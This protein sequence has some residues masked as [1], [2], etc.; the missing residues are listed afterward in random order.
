MRQECATRATHRGK[1]WPDNTRLSMNEKCHNAISMNQPLF[2]SDV[3]KMWEALMERRRTR[4]GMLIEDRHGKEMER[5]CVRTINEDCLISKTLWVYMRTGNGTYI[6]ALRSYVSVFCDCGREKERNMGGRLREDTPYDNEQNNKV[7][8]PE[9]PP[10]KVWVWQAQVQVREWQAQKYEHRNVCA[11]VHNLLL[12]RLNGT[13]PNR[14]VN[15]TN[16]T[17]SCEL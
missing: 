13:R 14:V 6:I 10:E 8:N 4:E 15:R 11:P 5:R 1:G 16:S 17:G 12:W 2:S 3:L 7:D 9:K